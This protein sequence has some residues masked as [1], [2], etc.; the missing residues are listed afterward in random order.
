M[1]APCPPLGGCGGEGCSVGFSS[2]CS[3]CSELFPSSTGREGS[4]ASLAE[5]RNEEAASYPPGVGGTR[6]CGNLRKIAGYGLQ[7]RHWL[8]SLFSC[9]LSPARCLPNGVVDVRQ[10]KM[11]DT[12]MNIDALLVYSGGRQNDTPIVFLFGGPQV[13]PSYCFAR[14]HVACCHGELLRLLWLGQHQ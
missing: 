1:P 13:S 7:G 14:T 3:C 4:V 10:R 8:T 9:S 11:T 6:L 2:C 5:A 12:I